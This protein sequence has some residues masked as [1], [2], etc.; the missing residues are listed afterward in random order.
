M[1]LTAEERRAILDVDADRHRIRDRQRR[2]NVPPQE[3]TVVCEHCTALRFPSE[4]PGVCCNDGKVVLLPEVDPP[5]PL[6]HLLLGETDTSKRFLDKI[7]SFNNAFAMT[8]IGITEVTPLE[9]VLI[10][11]FG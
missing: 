8:S 11:A 7:R 4:R 10:P 6:R 9:A 1:N 3:M 2:A 5:E